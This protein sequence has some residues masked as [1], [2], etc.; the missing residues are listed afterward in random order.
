MAC[1]AL[2]SDAPTILG[3][4]NLCDSISFGALLCMKD[5]L[6]KGS[7]LSELTVSINMQQALCLL[8]VLLIA[9]TG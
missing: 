5:P 3:T 9:C 7:E 4:C 8:I 2:T 1:Q 6:L